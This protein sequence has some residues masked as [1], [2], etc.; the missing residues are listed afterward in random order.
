[1]S[2]LV[3][4]RVITYNSSKTVI[5]TLDSIYNQTYPNIELIISDDCSKD[6]T[7]EICREWITMNKERFIRVELLTVPQNTGVSAN[8]NRAESACKGQW[9]KG[10]AGDDILAPNCIEEFVRFVEQNPEAT[11]VFCKMEGFGRPQAE[12]DEYMNR[13]FDYSFFS[14]TT[15]E[16]YHRLVFKGNCLPAPALFYNLERAQ[17]EAFVNDER[18]PMVEDYPKWMQMTKAGVHFHFIDKV[19][20]RYRL[21]ENSISTTTIPSQRTRQSFALIYIYYVFKPRFLYYKSP[22]KKLGEVRKFV[23][24]ANTAWGGCFWGTMMVIDKGLAKIL[25]LF[26]AK[27]KV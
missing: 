4:V 7:V 12:V 1:M 26:G 25:N 27:L 6:D 10:I 23:H 16:Q 2:T 8:C 18:I 11:Y 22:M 14:L 20:V 13:C 24:A 19:L 3:S 9:I 21:S 17:K 15:E 5:E